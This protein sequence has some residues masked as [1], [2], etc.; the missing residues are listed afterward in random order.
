MEKWEYLTHYLWANIDAQGVKEY[1]KKTWP[2]FEQKKYMPESLIPFLNSL[3]EQGWELIHIEPIQGI[4]NNYDI[5]TK[6][7]AAGNRSFSNMFFC[8]FK[9]RKG[10]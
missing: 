5:E 1:I 7:A 3:G 8:V 9:R 6:F 4:G 10:G 2:D